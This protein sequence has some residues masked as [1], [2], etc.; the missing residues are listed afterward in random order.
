MEAEKKC[1]LAMVLGRQQQA[2]AGSSGLLPAVA[3]WLFGLFV[4]LCVVRLWECVGLCVAGFV[5]CGVVGVRSGVKMNSPTTTKQNQITKAPTG[6]GRKGCSGDGGRC[7]SR[8]HTKKVFACSTEDVCCCCCE[9][10]DLT[11]RGTDAK[12]WES[13]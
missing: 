7:P 3:G 6:V 8:K 2:P 12:A 5:C 4:F 13:G 10:G 9:W 11:L 1:L